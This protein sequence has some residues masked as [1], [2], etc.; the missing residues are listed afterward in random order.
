MAENLKNLKKEFRQALKK[1]SFGA[2]C[3][4]NSKYNERVVDRLPL[5]TYGLKLNLEA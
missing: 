3:W 4:F 5:M 2:L 1:K